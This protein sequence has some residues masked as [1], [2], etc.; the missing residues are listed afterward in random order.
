LEP[1]IRSTASSNYG[2]PVVTRGPSDEVPL[3]PLAF[4]PPACRQAGSGALAA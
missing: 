3:R 1:H 4:L 2:L